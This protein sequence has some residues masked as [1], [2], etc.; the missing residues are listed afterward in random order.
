MAELTPR[1]VRILLVGHSAGATGLGFVTPD[2]ESAA[3]YAHR[4]A[5]LT[6]VGSERP[7][8]YFKFELSDNTPEWIDAAEKLFRSGLF[9]PEMIEAAEQNCMTLSAD[10]PADLH[11]ELETV[12]SIR[13]LSPPTTDLEKLAREFGQACAWHAFRER[14]EL[15][16]KY[17]RIGRAIRAVLREDLQMLTVKAE[18]RE[19]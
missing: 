14:P 16:Q 2:E 13:S 6:A 7:A 3:W 1:Q 11:H 8:A 17:E 15:A 12:E 18:E 9:K 5:F 10:Q 4:D 19:N